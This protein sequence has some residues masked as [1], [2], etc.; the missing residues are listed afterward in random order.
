[1]SIA[2]LA[3]DRYADSTSSVAVKENNI[4]V[5]ETSKSFGAHLNEATEKKCPYSFLA[6]DG[7]INYKDKS[8]SSPNSSKKHFDSSS[9]V[10]SNA[11][12]N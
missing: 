3:L 5:D 7:I 9:T 6:K 4:G 11:L 8:L 2:A 10:C 12:K 1:M